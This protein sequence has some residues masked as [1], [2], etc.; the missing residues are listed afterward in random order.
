[1]PMYVEGF[2]QLNNSK[3]QFTFLKSMDIA[4]INAEVES[5]HPR[6]HEFWEREDIKKSE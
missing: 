2:M 1:M 5:I 4:N 3:K 6:T